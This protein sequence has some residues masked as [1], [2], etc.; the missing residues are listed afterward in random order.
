[1]KSDIQNSTMLE[2]DPV[3][4]YPPPAQFD[5]SM[6]AAAQP[7]EP[8]AQSQTSQRRIRV[9]NFLKGRRGLLAAVV[10]VAA[11]LTVAF[12]GMLTLR[13]WNEAR[14]AEP[15]KEP[16]VTNQPPAET[17]R[18]S[19]PAHSPNA[20]DNPP[21]SLKRPP[22]IA[23]RMDPTPPV[24]AEAD[25]KPVARKVGVILYGAEKAERRDKKGNSRRH[26]HG[27]DEVDP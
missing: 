17:P 2:N 8:L 18:A 1:M 3:T 11:L 15:Q 4:P 6:V 25:N 16:A 5:E 21:R 14:S 10:L 23:A 19:I 20:G 24:E 27:N 26:R 12:A 9:S 7:V 22:A 13:G